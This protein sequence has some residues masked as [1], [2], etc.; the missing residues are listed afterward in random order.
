MTVIAFARREAR[1]QGDWRASELNELVASF[2]AELADGA[3]SGWE[4]AAT[5]AG[6]PQFYLIGPPPDEECILC[7][8][9]LGRSYVVEDG[10][11]RILFEHVKFE[12]IAEQARAFLK[13]RKTGLIARLTLL[14][15]ALRH[16]MEEKI[17][18]LIAD[19]E[20]FLMHV[21]PKLT[22]LA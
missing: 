17:E 5:E 1:R 16:T 15:E 2:A 19:A 22:V 14:C 4:I 13:S 7:V 18:P 10:A 21:A 12:L 11:G 20:E 3:A 8:S 6:D 9:R